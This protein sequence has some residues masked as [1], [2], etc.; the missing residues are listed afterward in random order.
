MTTDLTNILKNDLANGVN[1]LVGAGFSRLAKAGPKRTTTP[2]GNGLRDELVE[3]F[4]IK[5]SQASLP[6]PKLYSILMAG[7]KREAVV[8]YLTQR[9][10][11]KSIDPLYENLKNLK[12]KN[13]ITTN[14]DDLFYNIY[15]KGQDYIH[16]MIAHGPDRHNEGAINYL[17]IHGSVNYPERGYT[18][19]AVDL[20]GAYKSNISGH[21]TLR[22]LLSSAPTII[23]GY[24]MEDPGILSMFENSTSMVK[25]TANRW[26]F[27]RG[28]D[29]GEHDYYRS[30]GLTPFIG[31]TQEFLELLGTMA[32]ASVDSTKRPR[33]LEG[34]PQVSEISAQSM[35]AYFSGDAP[36]WYDMYFDRIPHL[37]RFS[38]ILNRAIGG[39][40]SLILGVNYSGK[41]TLLMQIAAY[42]KNNTDADIIFVDYLTAERASH[43]VN[44]GNGGYLIIDNCCSS[45]E[46]FNIAAKSGKFIIVAADRE[47]NYDI[48]IQ[49]IST[50]GFAIENISSLADQDFPTIYKSIPS[51]IRNKTLKV[52]VLNNKSN[53]FA[54]EFVQ[55]NIKYSEGRNWQ[56][57]LIEDVKKI[58]ND[59]LKIL[60]MNCFVYNCR[61]A[62]SDELVCSFL[63]EYSKRPFELMTKLRSYLTE[64]SA[65]VAAK[66]LVAAARQDFYIPRSNLFADQVVKL[67]P[68]E[69]FR[70]M[71]RQFFRNVR[72]DVVPRWDN[73][74]I[75]AYQVYYT[76]RVFPEWKDGRAFYDELFDRDQN[77]YD[78]QHA[79]LYLSNK[80]QHKLA[81]SYIDDALQRSG[82][83]IFSIRNTHAQVLFAANI[84]NA[85]SNEV[86]RQEVFES[87][88]ILTACLEGDRRSR[89]HA[90]VYGEQS[91]QIASVLGAKH[92]G[93]YLPVAKKALEA[94]ADK[95]ATRKIRDLLREIA[96]FG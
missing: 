8:E 84:H 96:R 19:T 59:L 41:T 32:P 17:P 53:P 48:S 21:E 76:K 14:I 56:K 88:R 3:A 46:G 27:T 24:S 40:N 51:S 47:F 86:A 81:F 23:I 71:Y 69:D 66:G 31:G 77:Y 82:N 50:K 95:G 38:T 36:K 74:R 35:E 57:R 52:P 45:V 16:D 93:A 67:A 80:G 18:F 73:F 89:N 2:T 91:L 42:L 30:L 61:G 22:Y 34:L 28:T 7:A 92:A 5:G 83:R 60:I 63:G 58:D 10:K 85:P 37:E 49:H 29:E 1:L 33:K 26:Y 13:V 39:K 68:D 25:S 78:L 72:S 43:L 12:I 15:S 55:Q 62:I 54:L 6:L 79:A 64:V 90:I 9:F 65:Y 94:E 44:S 11:V 87:M 20:A 70:G 75:S 4:D